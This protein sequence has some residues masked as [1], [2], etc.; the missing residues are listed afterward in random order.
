MCLIL[1]SY[2]PHPDYELILAAN[3]DEFYDRPTLPLARW[4]DIKDI[5]AGR[6]VKGSGTWLGMT[7]SGRIAAI[8][9]YRDPASLRPNAPSRGLVVSNFL[10]GTESGGAY[11]Q[12]L[13]KTGHQYNGFNLIVGDDTGLWYY[14]NRADGI[15]KLDPG[16]YGL[17]NRLLNT[18]WPKVDKGKAGMSDQLRKNREVN[19]D[20]F[21]DLLADRSMAPDEKLPDTGVGLEWERVLSSVFITSENYG[22]RSSSILLI[23]KTGSVTFAERTFDVKEPARLNHETRRINFKISRLTV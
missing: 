22:T 12:R 23:E 9:N 2:K 1:I 20:D 15:Q 18:G 7:R 19:P 5:Y 10:S 11:L 16:L 17:S 8:T 6:D 21:F 13:K 3:R 4:E 14:S